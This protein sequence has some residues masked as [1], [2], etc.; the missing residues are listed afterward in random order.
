MCGKKMV[1]FFI[2][3]STI[4][5]TL[6]LTRAPKTRRQH[7][8]LYGNSIIPQLAIIVL[9]GTSSF[10]LRAS[11]D[12]LFWQSFVC[13]QIIRWRLQHLLSWDALLLK[14]ITGALI[15]LDNNVVLVCDSQILSCLIVVYES[16][17]ILI[18]PLMI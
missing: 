5:T 16:I 12:L 14:N 10:N 6:N 3:D 7:L 15:H 13:D 2:T 9:K 1:P 4:Q 18:Y 11:R 17:S 8:P